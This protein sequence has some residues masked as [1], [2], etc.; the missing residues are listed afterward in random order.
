MSTFFTFCVLLNISRGVRPPRNNNNS[1]KDKRVGK[2][3]DPTAVERIC[4]RE[5]TRNAQPHI[6]NSGECILSS[7]QK[8]E[9]LFLIDITYIEA[10]RYPACRRLLFPQTEITPLKNLIDHII[11]KFPQLLLIN[12]LVLLLLLLDLLLCKNSRF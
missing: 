4:S 11:T 9:R 6:L 12:N 10:A 1:N 2:K 7:P 3:Y 8:N 5:K